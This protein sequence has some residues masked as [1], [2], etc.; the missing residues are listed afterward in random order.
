MT[1][2]PKPGRPKK[3]IF[4]G[5]KPL[6]G[7]HP[8]PDWFRSHFSAAKNESMISCRHTFRDVN[9]TIDRAPPEQSRTGS[10]ISRMTLK[11][12]C[13]RCNNGWMSQIQE[14]AKPILIRFLSEWPQLDAREQRILSTWAT[15]FTMVI[16]F[17]DMRYQ[18]IPYRHRVTL[19]TTK[20]P[21]SDWSVFIAHYTGLFWHTS[22]KHH[23][24]HFFG[25]TPSGEP[26]GRLN[27][28]TREHEMKIQVTTL[29]FG[30]LLIQT[31]ST[32]TSE[33]SKVASTARY[34]GSEHVRKIFVPDERIV[35]VPAKL[36]ADH[37]F[38]P[39]ADYI[40]GELGRRVTTFGTL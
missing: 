28:G 26:L 1:N 31:F 9:G 38:E 23:V 22:L 10:P 35:S 37:D 24:A 32:D 33:I 36:M 14:A 17:D 4:C 18:A 40:I 16:D 34:F 7:E 2:Q 5:R 30:K 27:P 12:V 39:F 15:M 3:C 19:R 29:A 6:T 25:E 8:W 11:V 21:P 20:R 13:A